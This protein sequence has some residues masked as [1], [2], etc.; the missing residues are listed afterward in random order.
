LREKKQQARKESRTEENLL[1][2]K[3]RV[4]PFRALFLEKKEIILEDYFFLPQPF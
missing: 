2:K 4:E 3:K 1:K